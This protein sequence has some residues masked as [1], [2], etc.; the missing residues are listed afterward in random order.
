MRIFMSISNL[1]IVEDGEDIVAG[2][3]IRSLERNDLQ[4][5]FVIWKEWPE[6]I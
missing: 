1:E 2:V 4:L 3:G 6:A 5:W